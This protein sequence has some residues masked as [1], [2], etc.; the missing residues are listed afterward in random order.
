[1]SLENITLDDMKVVGREEPTPAP[2]ETKQN[3]E[4][5]QQ[6]ETKAA[7]KVETKEPKPT[8][9]ETPE[10]KVAASFDWKEKTGGEYED[11]D[12]LWNDFTEYKSK[13]PEVKEVEKE[14]SFKDDYIAKAVAYYEENGDLTPFLEATKFNYDDM[15]DEQVLRKKLRDNYKGLG[16]EAFERKFQ[17]YMENN[18]DPDE[19]ESVRSE[20]MRFEAK[21]VREELK[22]KQQDFLN[23]E[24]KAKT[25]TPEVDQ[26]EE[27]K[28]WKGI[29]EADESVKSLKQEKALKI[30]YGDE[31]FTYEI[32]DADSIVEQAV[33][34]NKFWSN[35]ATEKNGE[36]S[37]D[38][39]KF[40][41]VATYASDPEAYEKRLIEFGKSLGKENVIDE[42][43]N[44]TEIKTPRRESS[45]PSPSGDWRD[46]FYSELKKQK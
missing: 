4:P 31:E 30:K 16:N 25:E 23:I 42:L 38:I 14:P 2:V 8:T 45:D 7:D 22:A 20:L 43:E 15:S 13:E 27:L 9:T 17:R 12:S 21:K 26:Q 44:P 18:F 33:D 11:F 39:S 35:F 36:P 28:K 29:V 5:V 10:A 34:S 41:K 3:E 24:P 19:D 46:E 40:T 32:G 6:T 37:V 1:M